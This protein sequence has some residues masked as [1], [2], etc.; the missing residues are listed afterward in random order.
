MK[1]VDASVLLYAVDESAE[2]HAAA[3]AWLDDALS[4]TASILMPWV[5]LLAFLRMARIPRPT[6]RRYGLP[7]PS[8]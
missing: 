1:L 8:T 3:K 6:H 4:G 2:H 7:R 5:C